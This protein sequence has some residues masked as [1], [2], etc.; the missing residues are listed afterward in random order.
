MT[1]LIQRQVCHIEF[2]GSEQEALE[3]QTRIADLCKHHLQPALEKVFDR[4]GSNAEYRDYVFPY[5]EIEVGNLALDQ[6]DSSFVERVVLAVESNLKEQI[7]QPKTGSTALTASPSGQDSQLK[8]QPWSV[9]HYFLKTG[10]LPWNFRLSQG[11]SLEQYLSG[12]LKLDKQPDQGALV[13]DPSTVSHPT[14]PIA[15]P[16]AEISSLLTNVE[17]A[18]KR[19]IWHF[20]ADFATNILA[21]IA[22]ERH[23]RWQNIIYNIHQSAALSSLKLEQLLLENAFIQLQSTDNEAQLIAHAVSLRLKSGGFNDDAEVKAIKKFWQE[24]GFPPELLPN[25]EGSLQSLEALP[26]PINISKFDKPSTLTRLYPNDQ[27]S[28]PQQT[29]NITEEEPEKS[30]WASMQ[31]QEPTE[32]VYLENAGLVI[33]HPFLTTFF[34]SIGVAVGEAL[35]Q[36]ER[37]LALLQHLATGQTT[38]AE[39]ELLLPKLLCNLPLDEP[40]DLRLALSET[41]VAEAHTLL[42][43]VI[44]HWTVLSNTQVDELRGNFLCRFGKLSRKDDG[45]WLLQIERQSFDLL[46]DQL[47]WGIGALKLPWMDKM[48]WVEW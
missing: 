30:L 23:L 34:E 11:L 45:D 13:L 12:F 25:M 17:A 18:R 19:L 10:N 7:G 22:P 15:F 27:V 38:F 2:K 33:L 42:S 4:V 21:I 1:H 9:L 28:K 36:P 46:L 44:Q 35:I 41:E 48:L 39:Y 43:A 14:E 29:Y 24:N 20:S 3:L 16:T 5:L 31:H 26:K 37:A 6:V 8:H 40:V 47:P 32:G